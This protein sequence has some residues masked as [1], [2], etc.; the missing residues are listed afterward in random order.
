MPKLKIAFILDDFPSITQ[1]FILS[2][3]NGMIEKGF[4]VDIYALREKKLS[5]VHY[6][7]TK[8]DLPSRVTFLPSAP[9]NRIFRV[10]KGLWLITIHRGYLKPELLLNLLNI[11]K[12]RPVLVLLFRALPFFNSGCKNYDVIHCQF[13]TVAP[14]ALQLIQVGALKGKL[15]T[16]FRGHDISQNKKVANGVYDDLFKYGDLFLPVSN[17]LKEMV[18]NAGCKPEKINVLH[19]GIDCYKFIYKERT[20]D[21]NTPVKLVT[22]ARLVEMKGLQYA[23]E[24]IARLIKLGNNIVYY[25]IGDGELKEKLN[26]QII[27]LNMSE[28]IILTGWLKHDEVKKHLDD[29]HIFV[30]PSVTAHNGEKEGI[31]NALKE[32]MAMGIP[33]ISTTHS[34]IP[35]LVEDSVSGYLVQ[36]RN[37]EALVER[38][39]YLYEHPEIWPKL[40]KA[41]Q[42][43]VFD[44]FNITKLNDK[45]ESIYKSL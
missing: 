39:T 30:T 35:E 1:T 5:K 28:K 23:I 42:K 7:V 18:I 17:S 29:A 4:E 2:Q 45:L 43:H 9:S 37:V 10:I 24:A 41:G 21:R 40:G 38:I 11:F 22:T 8:N 14:M 33:V 15:V 26:Q 36:E 27:Q 16:S 12:Y 31:P 6:E 13:G 3:I 34:G 25:I 19:S 44:H 32:A 20:H